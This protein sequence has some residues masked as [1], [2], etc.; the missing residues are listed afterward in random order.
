MQ[1]SEG[2]EYVLVGGTPVVRDGELVEGV[3]PGL[4]IYGRHRD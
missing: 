1:T 3:A 2:I 4:A